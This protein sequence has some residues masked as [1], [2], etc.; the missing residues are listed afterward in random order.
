MIDSDATL[1]F[2]NSSLVTSKSLHVVEH[3][4]FEVE[5]A[6]GTLLLC[7][8]VI[9]RLQISMENYTIVDDFFII[10]LVDTDIVLGIQW[11]ET[12][13]QYT[14]SFKRMDFSFETD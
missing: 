5:V 1:N 6:G 2:I 11:L 12:L 14:Q 9:R 13:D 4:R 7:T 3:E 10:D 8:H